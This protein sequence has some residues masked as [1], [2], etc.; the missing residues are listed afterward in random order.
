[1]LKKT[2]VYLV[3][4]RA[5]LI[6]VLFCRIVILLVPGNWRDFNK[7]YTTINVWVVSTLPNTYI[8]VR[9]SL[10]LNVPSK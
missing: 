1:M 9:Y 4:L 5:S 3:V 2:A 6:L 7:K 10:E 8:S